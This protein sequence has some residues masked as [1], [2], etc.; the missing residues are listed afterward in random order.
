MHDAIAPTA[1]VVELNAI[2]RLVV[3]SQQGAGTAR[4]D[5]RMIS[6]RDIWTAANMLVKRYGADAKLEAG[7]RA[8][9]LLADGDM[10]GQRVWLRIIRAVEELQRAERRDGEAVN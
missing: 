5:R 7:K 4:A 3:G 2:Q 6:E 1:P 8:D 9:E 10:E